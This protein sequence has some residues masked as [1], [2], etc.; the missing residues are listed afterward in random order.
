MIALSSSSSDSACCSKRVRRD[1]VEGIAGL[2][3]QGVVR[4]IGITRIV[5]ARA[6]GKQ[7]EEGR[8]VGIVADPG[9]VEHLGDLLF[10]AMGAPAS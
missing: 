1:L 2:A 4:R 3:D 9:V 7:I 8:R 10:M 5:L 6:A